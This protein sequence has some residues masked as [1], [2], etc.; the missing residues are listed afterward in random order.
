[1][2]N[3]N[4]ESGFLLRKDLRTLVGHFYDLKSEIFSGFLHYKQDKSR[5]RLIQ[6]EGSPLSLR[7]YIHL[8]SITIYNE[9]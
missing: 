9:I 4:R 1:M 7:W 5:L 8:L 2:S 3:R 6:L